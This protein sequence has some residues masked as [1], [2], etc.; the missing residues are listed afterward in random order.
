[1]KALANDYNKMADVI[2]NQDPLIKSSFSNMVDH[3]I[4]IHNVGINNPQIENENRI[5]FWK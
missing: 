2:D 3:S 1:M 5:A 4:K